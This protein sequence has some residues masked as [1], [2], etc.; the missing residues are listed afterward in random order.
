MHKGIKYFLYIVLL[1]VIL[2]VAFLSYISLTDYQPDNEIEIYKGQSSSEISDSAQFNFLIWNIGYCGL[3]REM[4][5]FYGGGK[6]VYP[7]DEV[8][9]A[10]IQGVKNAIRSLNNIDFALFQEV[11]LSSQRSHF[12]NQVDTLSNLFRG[13]NVAFGQNYL[14]PFVPVPISKPMGSVNS[15][16]LTLSKY[17]PTSIKRYAYE[18]NFSWPTSLFMLDRC[19]LVNRYPMQNGKEL[20]I[21]NTHNSEYDDGGL[22]VAQMKQ[23]KIFVEAEFKL[24]NY[25][26]AGGDWN[27]CAPDFEANFDMDRMDLVDKLDIPADLMSE[28]WRWFYDNKKPTNRRNITAY[29][30]GETLT[31]VIDFFLM[32]PNVKGLKIENL[33]MGFQYSDHQAVIATIQLIPQN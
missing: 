27:Q 13:F 15:G 28:G 4:D 24:G 8:V 7:S 33:E 17:S 10:N 12:T 19:F 5:F 14:V 30:K 29:T 25:I 23:L 16:L 21:I 2:F 9:F 31:T 18:G 1:I 20:L 26:I 6:Q 11:D 22:R 3:N 32:S